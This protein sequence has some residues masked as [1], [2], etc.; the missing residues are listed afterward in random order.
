MGGRGL[1]GETGTTAALK[2]QFVEGSHS[3]PSLVSLS[4][5]RRRV[6]LV[7]VLKCAQRLLP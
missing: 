7:R 3:C 5:R 1:G 6:C 2:Y 4:P